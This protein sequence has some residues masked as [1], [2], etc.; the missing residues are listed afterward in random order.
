MPAIQHGIANLQLAARL[1]RHENHM[2]LQVCH[3]QGSNRLPARVTRRVHAIDSE[4]ETARRR[5]VSVAS[6]KKGPFCSG[7]LVKRSGQMGPDLLKGLP[8]RHCSNMGLY[9]DEPEG[10]PAPFDR[11]VYTVYRFV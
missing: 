8:P 9:S 1:R 4:P 6:T 2:A 7:Q 10:R 5:A 11:Y 3:M